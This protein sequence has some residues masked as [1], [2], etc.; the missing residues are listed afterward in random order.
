MGVDVRPCLQ[1]PANDLRQ[2]YSVKDHDG[3]R[4]LLKISLEQLCIHPQNRGGHFSFG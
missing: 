3:K 1:E 2:C 4:M